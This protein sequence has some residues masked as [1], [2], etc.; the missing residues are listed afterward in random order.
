MHLGIT[1]HVNTVA[2]LAAQHNQFNMSCKLIILIVLY[3]G[4]DVR[5]GDSS[6]K[7]GNLLWFII[8][9]IYTKMTKTN[10]TCVVV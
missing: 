9:D 1:L 6:M 2:L 4:V 3:V 7:M 8:L 5:E 10:S